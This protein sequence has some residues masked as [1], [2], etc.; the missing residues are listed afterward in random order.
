MLLL[1]CYAA[2]LFLLSSRV[3]VLSEKPFLLQLLEWSLRGLSQV[4]M[5]NNPLSGTLILVALILY[6]PWYSLTTTVGLLSSTLTA[7]IIG[8]DSA[9]VSKGVHGFNGALVALLIAVFS[10]MGDWYL[11]L[12]LP[13]CFAGA[14]CTLLFSGLATLLK[15]WDIPVM[16][17]PFN[18]A[19][20]LY[21]SATGPHNLYFPQ[22]HVQ[23]DIVLAHSNVT[24][25]DLLRLLE[26]VPLGVGQIFACDDL[27][28][29]GLILLAVFLFSPLLCVHA[30]LG[31]CVGIITGLSLAVPHSRLYSGLAGFN[32]ALGC[33]AIGGFFF[34]FN[35]KTHLFAITSAFLSSYTDLALINILAGVGLPACS[36]A[37][38]LTVALLVLVSTRKL[39]VHRI[40]SGS[41]SI[42]E[43]TWGT[44][45]TWTAVEIK[46]TDI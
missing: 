46:S 11:W 19:L 17:F 31:S 8:Q 26:G 34:A 36:W 15:V 35:W 29:C 2:P 27:W 24:D 10:A 41:V 30:L 23:P 37:A 7:L 1:K 40:P 18:S 20:S 43:C 14:S 21:M 4:I 16:V 39:S 3:F 33:M 22:Q 38:T 5:V 25:L 28:A 42:P 6:N 45:S 44:R 12:L 13:C 32:G 9:D